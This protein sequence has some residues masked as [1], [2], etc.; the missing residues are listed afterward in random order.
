MLCPGVRGRRVAGL[1]VLSI[2][3]IELSRFVHVSVLSVAAASVV[4]VVIPAMV[5]SVVVAITT[6][7]ATVVVTTVPG[8]VPVVR[9]AVI[10]HGSSVPAAVPTAVAP[11]ATAAAHQ[12]P[13]GDPGAEAN[14]PGRSHVSRAVP[15]RQIRC[16]VNN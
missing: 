7:I 4:V 8:G 15:G 10:D 11:A 5:I 1:E 12:C 14:D 3:S 9:P 6:V 13:D 2:L 16:A